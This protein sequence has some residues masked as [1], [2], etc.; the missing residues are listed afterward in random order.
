MKLQGRIRKDVP[1]SRAFSRIDL[2]ALIFVVCLAA[3]V[4]N[5]LFTSH[6]RARSDILVCQDNLAQIGRAYQLWANDHEDRHPFLVATNEGGLRLHPLS[7]N[8]Y[9]QFAWVSNG[10]SSPKVFVCP[11]DTNIIRVAKDFS[12][13]PDGGFMHPAY[14][15]NAVGYFLSFHAQFHWPRSILSGDRNID[16]TPLQG[17]SLAPFMLRAIYGFPQGNAGSRWNDEI[18]GGKGN[19]LLNDGSAEETSTAQ[20]RATALGSDDTPGGPGTI[21]A[22]F[23]R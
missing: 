19:L 20:L 9:I 15:N 1:R 3:A 2:I 13:S 11:A 16:E 8:P 4:A 23:P 10:L 18:H 5:P 14:R 7:P 21:H 6:S 17:C 22:L 12:A